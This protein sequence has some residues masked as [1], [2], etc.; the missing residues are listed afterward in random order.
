MGGAWK[1]SLIQVTFS[2]AFP[3]ILISEGQISKSVPNGILFADHDKA[4][5]YDWNK[6]ENV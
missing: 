5:V 3:K 6:L 1:L 4:D 2:R